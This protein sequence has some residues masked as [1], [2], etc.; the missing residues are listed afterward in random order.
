[1]VQELRLWESM[2]PKYALQQLRAAVFLLERGGDPLKRRLEAAYREL[3]PLIASDFPDRLGQDF[4]EVVSQ[5][6]RLGSVAA[7]THSM[8]DREASQIA[9]SIVKLHSATEAA[10]LGQPS[11]ASAIELSV[12]PR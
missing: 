8:T 1:M 10:E 9:A 3:E 11:H 2:I 4:A 6:T 12:V 7:T 5:L